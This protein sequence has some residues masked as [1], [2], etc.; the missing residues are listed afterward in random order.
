[1]TENQ[2]VPTHNN[3]KNF[4]NLAYVMYLAS[5]F[6]GVSA[7]IGVITAYVFRPDAP[8]WLKTHYTYMINT[9]WKGLLFFIISAI[10]CLILI[11]FILI[12]LTYIWML[13]RTLKG[14]KAIRDNQPIDD[15]TSWGF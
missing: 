5:V 11:G 7:I 2:L 8:E 15:P 3:D 13:V 4:A 10:L 12:L 1:M 6:F 14:L 9:F